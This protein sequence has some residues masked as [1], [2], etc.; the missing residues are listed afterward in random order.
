M[1]KLLVA[2]LFLPLVVFADDKSSPSAPAAAPTVTQSTKGAS[3]LQNDNH[4]VNHDGQVV[5][6]PSKTTS[7]QAPD[8][9]T[10]KCRDGSFSFSKHHSGTCSHHGGVATW[11]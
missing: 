10:A 9:A 1:K 2:L 3:D 11:L 4:Y 8:G 6:S 5:H 7:G